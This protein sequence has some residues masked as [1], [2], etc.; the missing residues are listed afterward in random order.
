MH[1]FVNKKVKVIT[2]KIRAHFPVKLSLGTDFTVNA[3]FEADLIR[4]GNVT[5][6][7]LF[8]F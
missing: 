2:D 6:M 7:N 8:L 4:K 1:V 3:L 5:E